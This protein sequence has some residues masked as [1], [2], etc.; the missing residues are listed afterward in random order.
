LA[1]D[2]RAA[3]VATGTTALFVTHDHDEAFAVADRIAVMDLGRLLQ[4]AEPAELWH[5]PAS[6]R[7]A[8]F[9]GY[10]A[11]VPLAR[12][13]EALARAV[14]VARAAGVDGAGIDGAGADGAGVDGAEDL[15]LALGP[16]SL[17]TAPDGAL[18][19]EVT[20]AGFRRGLVETVAAVDGVGQVTVVE[21][22]G[23]YAAASQAL[24]VPGARVRLA[25]DAAAIA[26]VRG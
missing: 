4:V 12:A 16:G 26:V 7:V 21:P 19:G 3:L 22:S 18:E 2:V 17:V 23:G 1:G 20:S 5:R 24:P 15:V 14:G 25:V 13:P 8:E 10:E 9:L 6:R 11:F